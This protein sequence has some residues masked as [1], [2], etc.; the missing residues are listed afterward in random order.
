MNDQKTG[1]SLNGEAGKP[2]NRVP[3]E[4]K[5]HLL[6]MALLSVGFIGFFAL[7]REWIGLIFAHTAA[8][9]IM[10]FYGSWAGALAKKKGYGFWKV[11]SIGFFL[12]IILG[13][14]SAFLFGPAGEKDLLITCGGW[15][16]LGSGLGVV[17]FFFFVKKKE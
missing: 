2:A 10:G 1:S 9:G 15:V 12:P 13:V 16:A 5:I 8:L 6:I 17:I 7:Q 14:I 3:I 11:F 4:T